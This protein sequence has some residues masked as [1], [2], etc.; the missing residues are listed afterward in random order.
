MELLGADIGLTHVFAV[1]R[2]LLVLALGLTLARVA[3]RATERL[4]RP[5][6]DRQLA[7]L[8]RKGVFWSLSGLVLITALHQL[9]FNLG[10]LLGAAGIITVALGF[11]SQ[12]AASNLISGLFLLGEKP[13][14]V[15]DV[16][17][18]GDVSGE[19]LSIDALSVK[20]RTFDNIFVR[21]PNE[22]I[23]KDRVR[24]MTR[25]PIRRFDLKLIVDFRVDLDRLEAVLRSVSDAHPV[26]L[27]EPRP[28]F[29]LLGFEEW[30][31][32]VQYSVWAP[33]E[34]FFQFRNEVT[35]GVQRALIDAGIDIPYRRLVIAQ[36][37]PGAGKADHG[38]FTH[39]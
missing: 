27:Q 28:L 7:M 8:A 37:P 14:A 25:F 24:T 15:G 31:I 38:R 11:A 39:G 33:R 5:R 35:A 16:I 21:I 13:F 30:G 32:G 23:L 26:A 6:D 29:L 2:A 22:S 3:A 10:V 19:V 4:L 34:G 17:T 12:T 1:L 9:G 36:G 18:V 20:L